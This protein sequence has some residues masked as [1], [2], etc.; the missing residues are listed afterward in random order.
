MP[1]CVRQIEVTLSDFAG[2]EAELLDVVIEVS[3]SLAGLSTAIAMTRDFGRV[4]LGSWYGEQPFPLSLGKP[5]Y[6]PHSIMIDRNAL[7]PQPHSAD[8]LASVSRPRGNMSPLVQA[9]QIRSYLGH[10]S[11]TP[12][13]STV[14]FAG[15]GKHGDERVRG[16]SR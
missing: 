7:P 11:A 2:D 6:R 8:L 5:F 12:T 3:G 13:F 10:S 1:W 9:A 14:V 4:I 15:Q 16:L